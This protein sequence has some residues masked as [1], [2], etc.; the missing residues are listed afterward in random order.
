VSLIHDPNVTSEQIMAAVD[1]V[2]EPLRSKEI[3]QDLLGRSMTKLRSSLYD[4]MT[5]FAGFGRADLLASFALFDDNPERINQLEANFREVTPELIR[6]TAATYLA[7]T[8]RTVLRLEPG[9]TAPRN[10]NTQGGGK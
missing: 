3:D 5:E 7:R 2:I 8:N 10:P 6:K 4:S 9:A 1:S